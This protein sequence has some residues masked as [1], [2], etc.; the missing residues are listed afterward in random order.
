M[1]PSLPDIYDTKDGMLRVALCQI[2]TKAWDLEGNTQRT[3]AALEEAGRQHADIAITPECV[4]HGYGFGNEPADTRR[5]CAEI[6]EPLDG[7]RLSAVRQIA[8]DYNM[9]VVAGF[10]EAAPAGVM[11]D[12]A[13]IVSAS[14][15]VLDVYRKVH[16]RPAESI[17]HSGAFTPGNRFVATDFSRRDIRCR[18]GTMICFDREVP[19]STRCLR[20]M[21][22]QII[23]CPMA[24]YTQA[25]DKHVDFAHNEMITRCRAAENEV[26][27]VVVNH[28]G[29]FNGGSFVAGPGGET[30][31]QLGEEAEVRVVEIPIMALQAKV[32]SNAYGWMGWGFRRQDVY[33]RHLSAKLRDTGNR[34]EER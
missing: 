27:F 29:T 5:R 10:V 32:H 34:I 11:H 28:S 9:Y 22:A 33:D 14:G 3:L 25:L 17:D 18:L 4:F 2:L 8:R 16:C 30:L 24:W 13:G 26:F 15:Q 23:A 6:A 21:G 1:N 19:E 31:V 20:A 7:P 12:S